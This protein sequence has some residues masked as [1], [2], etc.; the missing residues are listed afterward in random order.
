VV[1]VEAAVVQAVA[2]VAQPERL[3]PPGGSSAGAGA[4]VAS[5]GA[6]TAPG[7]YNTRYHDRS[8]DR[9]RDRHGYNSGLSAYHPGLKC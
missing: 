2:L 7:G 3:E 4:G 5:P 6:T 1:V 8:R 9:Q